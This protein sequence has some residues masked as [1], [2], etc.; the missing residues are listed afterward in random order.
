[1]EA[2]KNKSTNVD[3]VVYRPSEDMHI[4]VRVSEETV[5]LAQSQMEILFGVKENTIKYHIK[6]IYKTKE[7]EIIST[8][9]KFRVVRTEGFRNISRWI[10]FYNLDM[11]ISVGYRVNTKSGVM[12][13]RWATNVLKDYMLRG[14]ALNPYFQQVEQHLTKHDQEIS[15]LNQRIDNM[16]KTALPPKCGLFFN[17]QIF[18]A[19]V[20][21]AKLIKS[22]KKDIKLIDNYIDESV[23]V[24]LD[25]RNDKVAA[26]IFTQIISQQLQLDIQRHN[27]QYRPIEIKQMSG[28]HDRFMLID[29]NQLYHIGASIKDLGKKLFAITLIE[30]SEIIA[31]IR[32]TME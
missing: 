24:L 28:V 2:E 4:D 7:L 21:M 22:A 23:L 12:F 31:A 14:S 11:I 3:L 6:E 8:T 17:G 20:L 10:D 30:D 27:A 16:V 18:D 29:D 19:Y 5:W 15:V 1:M 32:K 26:T 13:R 9:R 25:K